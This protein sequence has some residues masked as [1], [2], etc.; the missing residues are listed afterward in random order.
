MFK[1][2]LTMLVAVLLLS[3]QGGIAQAAN[4]S[5]ERIQAFDFGYNGAPHGNREAGAYP[6]SFT[7]LQSPATDPFGFHEILFVRITAGHRGATKQ[8]LIAALDAASAVFAANGNPFCSTCF[9]DYF[10]GGAFG[11]PGTTSTSIGPDFSTP[12]P[13]QLLRG[14]YAYFCG[15]TEADGTPHYKLGMLGTFKA[16]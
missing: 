1:S 6:V 5:G 13:V 3:G 10:A 7:N 2:A 15:V 4:D 9:F 12:G 11:P 8:Q 14:D 16:K